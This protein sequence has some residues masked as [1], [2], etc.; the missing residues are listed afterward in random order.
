MGNI[1]SFQRCVGESPP[2]H[3]SR[4][5]YCTVRADYPGPC[6]LHYE[7]H[8]STCVVGFVSY[9]QALTAATMAIFSKDHDFQQVLITASREPDR[10]G[11]YQ[12]AQ[13]WLSHIIQ[14]TSALREPLLE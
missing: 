13:T 9:S 1:L 5:A 6:D 12:T 8:N 3:G 14:T 7:L 10:S 4:K 2:A 11:L